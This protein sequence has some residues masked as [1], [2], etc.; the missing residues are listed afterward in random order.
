MKLMSKYRSL[1]LPTK[2]A[3]WFAI[4]NIIQKGIAFFSV[5]IL[6][7]IMPAEDYGEYSVFL[8]WYQ[9]ISIFATLNMW[10]YVLN[11]GMV[12]FENDR[13]GFLSSLQGLSTII[14]IGLFII[15]LPFCKAWEKVSGLSFV[16]MLFMFLEFLF[17]PS[18]EYWCSKERFEYK[19]KGVVTLSIAIALLIPLVSIPIVMMSKNKGMA[20]IIVRCVISVL[21]YIIPTAIIAFSGRKFYSAEYWKFALHFNM[22]LIPHFLSM[23]VLQ[24]SD[25]IMIS[26]LVGN[27]KA[28]IYSV[29][30]T[31]SSAIQVINSAILASFVPYTYKALKDKEYSGIRKN[32]NYLVAFI[33]I[34]N[35][36]LI[37]VAPEA[38][39]ILGPNEYYEAI[40]VMPPVAVSG[41]FIFLFNLFANIEYYFEETKFVAMASIISAIM[42]IVLNAIFIPRFGFV[43]A[44]YTTLVCYFL[45]SLG[46][47][48]FMRIVCS[49][50]LNGHKVYDIKTIC[51]I[52]AASLIS[53]FIIMSLYDFLIIRYALVVLGIALC[54]IKFKKGSLWNIHNF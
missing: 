26:S 12:K 43:A 22:P 23:I 16:A 31:A 19:Y 52:I 24:Q 17:M 46:H 11:N 10:N 14:T 28:G 2:A 38:I 3:L 53:A 5:P 25:R 29:A 50:H 20:A 9:I 41:V 6:T 54:V 45:Y 7:R 33:A 51:T 49:K 39:K 35:L 8:S 15:Y 47:Y 36:I 1:S 13:S 37:C 27:D 18:Y 32:A 40:Y 44:G 30:Y 21:V 42:N 4:S 34:L 48:I